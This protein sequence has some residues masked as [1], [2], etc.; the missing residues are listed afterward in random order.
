MS[1]NKQCKYL[2]NDT[3]IQTFHVRCAQRL[4]L[5]QLE[6]FSHGSEPGRAQ[7]G[8][9]LVIRHLHYVMDPMAVNDMT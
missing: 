7:E 5:P 8:Q 4:L 1:C 9:V 3:L 6:P 2:G